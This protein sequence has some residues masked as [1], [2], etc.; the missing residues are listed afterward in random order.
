MAPRDLALAL[1]PLGAALALLPGGYAP[2]AAAE[3]QVQLRC[4]G[5]WIQTRGTAQLQRATSRLAVSLGLEAEGADSDAAL[6]AL[7]QRLAAVRMALQRLEVQDLRVT[8]PST[9]V[10]PADRRR[11][12]ITQASLQ[13]SGQLAP[14]RL[15][16][17]VRE[18][19]GL[20]GVRLA[21]V[22]TQADPQGDGVARRQLLREAY[23]DA[24][25]QALELAAVAG[26]SRV[27][28]LEL[29][30]D[31]L[32]RPMSL[33]AMAATADGFDPKELPLPMDRVAMGVSFCA[34]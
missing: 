34:S 24:R 16:A 33:R 14:L 21:P 5:A 10:R 18:V 6:A 13:V 27:V 19:G 12:A 25:G 11:P 22:T 8:S 1:A 2:A 26:F 3:A 30:L 31:G 7:Q 28:P 17:L 20:P 4:E 29:R 23:A 9:W 15:Q 32:E